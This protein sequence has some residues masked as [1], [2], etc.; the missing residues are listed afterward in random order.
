MG[1]IVE[2]YHFVMGSQGLYLNSSNSSVVLTLTG[3]TYVPAIIERGT[4]SFDAGTK[5]NSLDLK[6]GRNAARMLQD[7]LVL[8][9]GTSCDFTLYERDV[10]LATERIV[11]KGFIDEFGLN[12]V[13]LTLKVKSI[14]EWKEGT[15]LRVVHVPNCVL[16]LYSERCA[17][18]KD[19][20]R[21]W[22][23]ISDRTGGQLTLNITGRG[24]S[25]PATVPVDWMK[26]SVLYIGDEIRMV[27][28]Q[29]VGTSAVVVD[30]F[31]PFSPVVTTGKPWT[32]YAGCDK[33]IS[34]CK[35]KFS[36]L[37][38]YL[39]F[40]HAPLEDTVFVGEKMSGQSGGKK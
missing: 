11:F 38:N 36:N 1:A 32:G 22:G 7:Y 31:Y 40:P 24:A 18:V 23:I 29:A 10:D 2:C 5:K 16:P 6:I 34:T 13:Y 21:L 26:H 27:I 35:D 25:V 17:A 28:K 15:V 37:V 14:L 19:S 33:R 39:G 8:T 9:Q 4:I 3:Q 30:P 12:D 20:Y